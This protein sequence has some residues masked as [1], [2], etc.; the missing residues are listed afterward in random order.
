MR[1]L[2]GTTVFCLI[3][4][5]L[6]FGSA[7]L[8]SA[9]EM[10]EGGVDLVGGRSGPPTRSTTPLPFGASTIDGDSAS[11]TV[12]LE[13]DSARE[14][15]LSAEVH[16]DTD[17]GSEAS[18]RIRFYRAGGEI[19]KSGL[20]TS[21]SLAIYCNP[22]PGSPGYPYQGTEQTFLLESVRFDGR[23]AE[24]ELIY[25]DVVIVGQDGAEYGVSGLQAH[26]T[27]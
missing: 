25:A 11:L 16:F 7:F 9:Q 10:A 20:L 12:R 8:I 17:F 6:T 18:G 22:I 14:R 26:V 13:G 27:K 2:L 24:D 23:L 5:L 15:D 1:K 3:L 21:T 19:I 4:M